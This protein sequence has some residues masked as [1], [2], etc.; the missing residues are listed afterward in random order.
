MDKGLPRGIRSNISVQ[1]IGSEVLIY[2][3][4]RHKAFCLNATSAAIWGLCDGEHTPA[5]IASAASVKLAIPIDEEIVRL[6]LRD[7]RRDG[8]VGPSAEI[9]AVQPVSRRVI[10]QRIGGGA[11][12]ML[13]MVAAVMAPTAAQAYSGCVDCSADVA[14]QRRQRAMRARQQ[15]ERQESQGNQ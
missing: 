14:A 13:P 7:L 15:T 11:A 10:L 4:L 8:L 9:A 1:Q 6:G 5:E 3:E 2:D 12:I